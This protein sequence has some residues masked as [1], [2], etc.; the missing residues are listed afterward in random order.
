MNTK[1][2]QGGMMTNGSIGG[3]VNTHNSINN[4]S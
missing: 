1:N 2:T 4:G 3:R